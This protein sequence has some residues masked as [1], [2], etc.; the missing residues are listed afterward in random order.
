MR[1]SN[2]FEA[3]CAALDIIE[4][5]QHYQAPQKLRKSGKEY[6]W[7]PCPFCGH[8]DCF[9]VNPEKKLFHCFSCEVSGNAVQFVERYRSLSRLEAA[10]ELS[11]VFNLEI[12]FGKNGK[13]AVGESAGK[14][15]EIFQAAAEFYRA[16]LLGDA[17]ALEILERTRKYSREF[18]AGQP[19]GYT[20][21]QRGELAGHLLKRFTDEEVLASG[22]VERAQGGQL[23]DF[24]APQYFVFFH[25]A[26][27]QVCDFS[28]KDALKHTRKKGQER[29]EYRLK[30]EYRLKPC[31][32]NQD[33]LH[34]E[35][36]YFCEGQN[37][38]LQILNAEPQ[39]G[40]VGEVKNLADPQRV[41]FLRSRIQGK[42]VYVVFDQD[43]A[44]RRFTRKVFD[45]FWGECNLQ[46]LHWRESEA[47]DI[48]EFLRRQPDPGAA[49]ARLRKESQ[50]I[51]DFL[52]LQLA[53]EKPDD[54]SACLA[55]VRPYTAL[56]SRV[57]DESLVHLAL[58]SIKKH[59][60]DSLARIILAQH[61]RERYTRETSGAS[62]R[63]LPYSKREG[64]YFCHKG[65][66]EVG[67][68]NFTLE[69]SD[70]VRID[71]DIFYRCNLLNDVGEEAP[72]IIF[73]AAERATVRRFR[74]RCAGAGAYYFTGNDGDLAGIWQLEEG[75]GMQKSFYIKHFG[76]IP[77][78]GMWLFDNCAIKS[79]QVY[80]RNE[81]GYISM[82][83][84]NFKSYDVQVY[85]GVV[86]RLNLE[87]PFSVEFAQK[88]A[89]GFHQQL[90]SGKDGKRENFAGYLFFGVLPAVIY[91]REIFQRFGF[92]P[93]LLAH[94][95][96]N[97]GKTQMLSL[98]LECFGFS[99]SP[100]SWPGATEPGTYQF[101]QALSSLPC[102]YDEFLNDRTFE[103]IFGTL[104]NIYN[105]SGSGKGGL[106]RR[107]IREVNG[108]LWLSGEDLPNNE[109]I[110]SRG[111][112]F[113]FAPIN[114]YKTVGYDYLVSVRK[115]LSVLSRQLILSKSP[116]SAAFLLGE[117]E[118]LVAWMRERAPGLE[119]RVAVNHAIFAAGLPLLGLEAPEGFGEYVCQHA[120]GG[121]A[122]KMQENPVYLFFGEL[123]FALNR[124]LPEVYHALRFYPEH[125]EFGAD[126]LALHFPTV[127]K[128]LQGELRRRG[129]SLKIK[130][131][132]VRDYLRDLP[133]CVDT[134]QMVAF[135][136][137]VSQRCMMFRLGEGRNDIQEDLLAVLRE[138][139]D[140]QPGSDLKDN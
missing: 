117:I 17:K 8:N 113:R 122:Q 7:N 42:T 129:E 87:T 40:A 10:K 3:V 45:T 140:L 77:Q 125:K 4:V 18:I 16:Q 56:F 79:G 104:K 59:F 82:E 121:Q 137:G 21:N 103:K 112:V 130:S 68:S 128:I 26:G 85:S 34:S 71:Q 6:S 99:T 108:C 134:Q 73:N 54:L 107:T 70:V 2:P 115:N 31:L 55:L 89:E 96:P 30:A 57:K 83:R 22:L 72:G 38:V 105:R 127:I 102:W 109:A 46:V 9:K 94:G 114:P 49:L 133:E 138:R 110:L 124:R 67:L 19:I 11:R 39:A 28:L 136:R 58:E 111:V 91:S 95:Q 27:G 61:K 20:G 88:V 80:E 75:Q 44:G 32:F 139:E 116:E 60:H 37:D 48:D 64:I 119:S 131:E 93:F 63:N 36:I 5:L 23:L 13:Y 51:F 29:K 47:K 24:F 92:F 35:I 100:E 90:D 43:E 81:E 15:A 66:S 74:E 135:R 69:I 126:V 118:R 14:Q 120:L 132:S 76:D 50:E 52:M 62:S 65:K 78:E 84:R 106:E 101:L 53:H 25:V 97:T 98:L 41:E 86:P 12:N 123:L 33:D 1:G